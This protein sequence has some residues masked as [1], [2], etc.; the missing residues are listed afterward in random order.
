MLGRAALVVGLALSLSACR[1]Q[2]GPDENFHSARELY[3]QLY[4][5]QL[6]EAYGDPRMDEVVALLE[7]VH[8]RSVDAPQAKAMLETIARGRET[9]AQ[10]LAAREKLAAEAA[11]GVAAPQGI[12]TEKILAAARERDAGAA[13]DP[14]G[15][16]AEIAALNAQSGGCM[17]ENEPFEEQGSPVRGSIYR[18][19]QSEDCK[20]RLPGFVGQAVLVVGGKIYRR[21]PDPAP[22]PPPSAPRPVAGAPRP[23]ASSAGPQ[24]GSPEGARDAG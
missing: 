2:R 20:K 16:G 4:A 24:A 9:L 3:Q 22:P 7:K 6:D 8:P 21:I 11:K 10:E 18:V 13:Q 17:T 15:T 5:T 23:A 14:Y 1:R 19:A 12:D